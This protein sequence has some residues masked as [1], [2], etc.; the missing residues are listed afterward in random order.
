MQATGASMQE[1]M[2]AQFVQNKTRL[3]TVLQVVKANTR[4]GIDALTLVFG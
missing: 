1:E 3:W 2:K 4:E